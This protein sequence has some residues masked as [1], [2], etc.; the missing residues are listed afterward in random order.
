MWSVRKGGHGDQ[1]GGSDSSWST[2]HRVQL[3]GEGRR[4]HPT[5]SDEDEIYRTD[6]TWS[7]YQDGLQGRHAGV[8][9]LFTWW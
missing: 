3:G 2:D 1:D 9:W 5:L 8:G 4:G 6:W 7:A